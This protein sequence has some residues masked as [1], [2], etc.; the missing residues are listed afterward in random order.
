[1][2]K[3]KRLSKTRRSGTC[4]GYSRVGM[5]CSALT[6][7]HS[8]SYLSMSGTNF[9]AGAHG[10]VA[11]NN[12]MNAANTINIHHIYGNTTCRNFCSGPCLEPRGRAQHLKPPDGAAV[13]TS[14]EAIPFRPSAFGDIVTAARLALMIHES[15]GDSRGAP[16]ELNCFVDELRSFADALL[17]LSEIVREIELQPLGPVTMNIIY[18]AATCLDFVK[19]V[20][21]GIEP[22]E[23][24]F[25]AGR[26]SFRKVWY[27]VCWGVFRPKEITILRKK[28]SQRTQK[29]AIWVGVLGIFLT[30]N[31]RK[32][33]AAIET[34]TNELL[35]VHK[36]IAPSISYGVGNTAILTDA[37]GKPI[38]LAMDF[39]CSPEALHNFL[40]FYFKEKIGLES[41]ERHEY[42][43]STEDGKTI[44][45]SDSAAWR[46]IVKEGAVLVMSILIRIQ[47]ESGSAKDQR[48][49]CPRC[50]R[51]DV[52][53]MRDQG[54]LEWVE[55]V[56][57]SK[58]PPKNQS[59]VDFRNLRV[60]PVRQ[61]EE[62]VCE[63]V[64][65]TLTMLLTMCLAFL[66][67]VFKKWFKY[68]MEVCE[69][70]DLTLTMLLTMCLAFLFP[71]V[72][73]LL[74]LTLTMLLTMC[75]AFL[76]PDDWDK[77]VR[78]VS[79]SCILKMLPKFES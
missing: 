74:D 2:S 15:L 50:F 37:F 71:E 63:L 57:A 12:T 8:P 22:Y 46:S 55:Y 24:A 77:G 60:I 9:F 26:G 7:L 75:L 25:A 27:K 4:F 72:C 29:I 13:P 16:H 5:A 68:S 3:T 44:M 53:V 31:Y 42:S 41:V 61:V 28:L 43:I 65:L 45:K 1:M 76:F 59:I 70:V 14:I 20:R 56:H 67:P 19:K 78:A 58:M 34:R 47:L 40:M 10:F 18:E 6:F 69:L 73:E 52:G 11:S 35:M 49:T 21:D 17:S 38:P 33:V 51:T 79:F 39:Y 62:E 54:W 36:N 30:S 64:D 23:T 66:F 32:T 48:N